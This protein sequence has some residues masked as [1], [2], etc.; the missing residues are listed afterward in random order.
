M[1]DQLRLAGGNIPNE[2]RV[3][4]CMNNVWGT[5]CDDSWESNDAT[6]VCRQLGYSTQGQI[7]KLETSIVPF[8]KGLKT[9]NFV[10][11][12]AL[13]FSN[14]HFGAGVGPIHIDN[15]ACSGSECSLADCPHSSFISRCN[16]GNA[17]VRCQGR[18]MFICSTL[19]RFILQL[20]RTTL[21]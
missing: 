5:V 18:V 13:A 6:V 10:L 12:G 16:N 3:E 2:G 14:A 21:L 19:A 11:T 1:T 7:K 9:Y 15:V 8:Q 17:G 20:D 4:I